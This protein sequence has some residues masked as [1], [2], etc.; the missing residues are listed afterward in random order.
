MGDS[1]FSP[2]ELP[3]TTEVG[4][5]YRCV[6][7]TMV[8]LRDETTICSTCGR[9]YDT[10]VIRAATAETGLGVEA[11]RASIVQPSHETP[12]LPDELIGSQLGHFKILDRI[13][14]GGMGTVYRAL[15]ESLQR[16]VAIKTLRKIVG[17]GNT[18][19]QRLFQEARAQARINHPHV[20]HIYYVGHDAET[21]YLAMELVGQE[22]L[23]HRMQKGPLPFHLIVHIA[24]QITAALQAAAQYDIVHGDIKPAN[25]LMVDER[26]VKLSDFGL[27]HR[28]SEVGPES[29]TTVGTPDYMPPEA[30]TGAKIDHYGDMYSL[31]VALFAMTFRRMP[32]TPSSNSLQDRLRQ[33]RESAVEFPVSWPAE[34]PH[35]WRGILQKLLEKNPAHRYVNFEAILADLDRIEPISLPEASPLLRG[36][37]WII[38]GFLIWPPL[39]II[40]IVFSTDRTTLFGLLGVLLSLAVCAGIGI[41]QSLWGTTPGKR[42]LQIR[43]VDQHGLTPNK[44]VLA[45]RSFFQFLWAWSAAV[46]GMMSSLLMP[47]LD[48]ALHVVVLLFMLA[49]LGLLL[50]A[51]GR[52]V[53]DRIFQTS[54]FLDAK[55]VSRRK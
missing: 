12:K 5:A 8:S 52:T 31:G 44:M 51:G 49:E 24:K 11:D 13:G 54:V 39:S 20:A 37:A 32:Y 9:K 2:L 15:D 29:R 4:P 55:V 16:Y 21:P 27:A 53:H 6:C 17:A 41:V 47:S 36:L 38:D 34:I 35:A 43:I 46:T 50:F 23:A 48:I 19:M 3:E 45:C 22:T 14:G 25:V 30:T 26:T 42:L 18:E 33:H 40:A 28:L 10:D 7:G 1:E